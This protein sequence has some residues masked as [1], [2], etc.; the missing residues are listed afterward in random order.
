[1]IRCVLA[2]LT[3][4][5]LVPAA[6]LGQAEDPEASPTPDSSIVVTGELP[7]HRE[8]SRQA[9]AI[10]APTGIRHAPL[11]RFEGDRLCPGVIGLKADYAALVIDRIRAHAERFKLWMT[12]D[13]GTCSAN[14]IVAFVD[15]GQGTLRQ[16][17]DRWP[18][19]F[20]D[21]PRHERLA[22]LADDGPVHVWTTTASRTSDGMPLPLRE[23][24]RQ[25]QATSSGGVA[26]AVLPVRSDITGV[27]IL[28]D[29][30]AVRDKT[31]LQLADYATMRGLART[32]PVDA[33]GATLDTILALFD[34]SAEPPAEL[35]EFDGAYL[36]ALYRGKP[37]LAGLNRLHTV[38]AEL[39]RQ[40]AAEPADRAAEPSSP[41]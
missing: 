6:A 17:A 27:L 18:W 4:A 35:T 13:D 22:L 25:V 40:A 23:D 37:N 20:I 34:A 39:R 8:V 14:F 41:E 7:T 31:L 19:M 21:M 29:R 28:F 38:N 24:G 33:D 11:P 2:G 3:C 9:R 15:D 36:G 1:M 26:R 30:T 32:R 5:A 16:I 12:E 10:T